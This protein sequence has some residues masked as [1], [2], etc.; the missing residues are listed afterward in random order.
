MTG[1]DWQAERL[2]ESALILTELLDTNLRS[3]YERGRIEHS[4]KLCIFRDIACGLNYLHQHHEPIIH[5]DVSATKVLL[6]ALPNYQWRA[7]IGG[8][9]S[10]SL[11]K[12]ADT[13][14][15]GAIIYSAPETLPPSFHGS[16]AL[17]PPQTT[18]IDVYSY[19]ILLC[20]VITNQFPVK[21]DY[22]GMLHQIQ[23][24]WPF[25]HTLIQSCTKRRPEERLTMADVLNELSRIVRQ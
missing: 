19:G 25:M 4:S 16:N 17:P 12:L 6:E 14:A 21:E 20:E 13:L 15:E 10:A 22:Q 23:R 8:F 9:G 7:K 24:Q 11:A 1:I 5:R 2:E 3:A 18:K